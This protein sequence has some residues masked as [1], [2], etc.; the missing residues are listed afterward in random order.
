LT[1]EPEITSVRIQPGDFI[2]L[3]SKGLFECLN[4]EEV[5]GLVGVWVEERRRERE[6]GGS[7]VGRQGP[8]SV[9]AYKDATFMAD[10]P[11]VEL[12]PQM[13]KI[14]SLPYDDQIHVM[15][16]VTEHGRPR[17]RRLVAR[18]ELPIISTSTS[19]DPELAR[20]SRKNDTLNS[21]RKSFRYS[22]SWKMHNVPFVF[23]ERDRENVAAHVLRNAVGG[24]REDF[25]R[26]LSLMNREQVARFVDDI[27][28]TVIFFD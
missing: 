26:A 8:V 17:Q 4:S 2:V 7:R 3:A 10:D 27:G 22:L 23:S 12:M 28:L 16:M 9:R 1:A 14:D 18:T 5:I 20:L 13:Q 6:K 15:K 19:D 24:E 11:V 25:V 21:A